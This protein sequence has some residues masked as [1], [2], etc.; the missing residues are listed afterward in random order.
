MTQSRK[1]SIKTD[2]NLDCMELSINEAFA[3]SFLMFIIIGMKIENLRFD[4]VVT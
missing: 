4:E 1:V 3:C 2:T